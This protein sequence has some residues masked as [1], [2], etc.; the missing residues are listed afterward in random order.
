LSLLTFS[1]AVAYLG[2]SLDRHGLS[3]DY[4]NAFQ[5]DKAFLRTLGRHLK[6]K[7]TPG[8]VLSAKESDLLVKALAQDI[9]LKRREPLDRVL[10]PITAKDISGE[11]DTLTAYDL[12]D[13]DDGGH[14]ILPESES[15]F[16]RFRKKLLRNPAFENVLY[17]RDKESGTITD[18][19][20]LITFDDMKDQDP[21]ARH[22]SKLIESHG[23]QLDVIIQGMP[24]SNIVFNNYMRRDLVRFLPIVLSVV[25]IVFFINFR[26]I[27]GVVL[28]FITLGMSTVW[29]LGLMGYLGIRITP[30]G[31]SLPPLMVAV[32]SSYA[33]HILN[34]YY[35]DLQMI[36]D[37]GLRKGLGLAMSHISF[38]V[39]LAGLTTFVAFMTLCTNQVPAIRQ[40]G[41]FSAVGVIFSVFVACTLIPAC[42]CLLPRH[43][44]KILKKNRSSEAGR[45]FIDHILTAMTSGAVRHHRAVLSVVFILMAVSAAGILRLNVESDFLQHFKKNAPIRVSAQIIEK[46]L[47]GRW[48][49][50]ILLDSGIQDGVKTPEFLNT[51]EA[52]RGWLTSERNRNL[53]ITRTDA[54]PD[55]IKT[56]HMAMNNDDPHFYAI[57]ASREEIMDYLEI[58]TGQDEDWDGRI[59]EFESYVDQDFRTVNILA[60]LAP[61]ETYTLGTAQIKRII[62][63]VDVHLKQTLPKPYSHRITGFP[64]MNVKMADYIIAGQLQSLVL[65]FV[66]IVIIVMLLFKS[67]KAAPLALIPMGVAV[68][69]SFGVMGWFHINLDIVTS[70]IAAITIGIGI[71][72][73]IHILNTY[74]VLNRINAS[75]E[76]AIANALKV[77]GKAIIYTSMA[78]IAGFAVL[79]TSS[80]KPVILFGLLMAVTMAATTIGAL[81]VLPAVLRITGVNLNHGRNDTDYLTNTPEV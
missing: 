43:P 21:V 29:V 45:T 27:R 54:F 49:F 80:F 2:T 23:R 61:R 69:I 59:D 75:V 12:V 40:W 55:F 26:S 25:V 35:I 73:T 41:I 39:F 67:I 77:S 74:R 19:G 58:Y 65:S 9:E 46:K 11:D 24:Y 50:N 68:T 18:F 70:I 4:I 44:P 37:K 14:R 60:R 13:K 72:D 48:G 36:A 71:D 16:T 47:A 34:Q 42:I 22:I 33:I 78:L 32:G 3:F 81:L 53:N 5:E 17:A 63:S 66:I 52:L 79:T 7:F 38:T 15:D 56:M 6:E 57:P 8:V 64:V 31:I 51:V 30:V 62:N 1:A 20:M 76:H 10:S 28:P